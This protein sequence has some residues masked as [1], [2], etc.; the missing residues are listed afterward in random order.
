VDEVVFITQKIVLRLLFPVSVSL[1]LGIAG[2]ILWRRRALSF[3]LLLVSILWLLVMSIPLTGLWLLSPLESQAGNYADP[4]ELANKGVKYIVVLSGGFRDGNLMPADKLDF[5]I[6]RLIEGIRLW[7]GV[8]RSKLVL[9]G[10]A[11]P[12]L[13]HDKSIA[14][15]FSDM[16][17]IMGVPADAIILEDKSWTTEDQAR[18]VAPIVGKS[19]FALVTSAF[20]MRRS[21]LNFQKVGLNPIPAPCDFLT[22]KIL[23]HYG[24]LTPRP[25]GLEL[26]EIATK[27]HVVAW[28][29]LLRSKLPGI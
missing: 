23:F 20:H 13:S 2:L 10:G 1:L 26:T 22:K 8:P 27:E 5:S 24:T 11:I 29:M 6:L 4:K 19:A 12:G 16:A 15:T 18:M 25:R 9:T 17:R 7:R 14:Q 3:F 28:W 21:I